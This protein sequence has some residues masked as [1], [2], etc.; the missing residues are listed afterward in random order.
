MRYKYDPQDQYA[1]SLVGIPIFVHKLY[2]SHLRTEIKEGLEPIPTQGSYFDFYL[3]NTGNLFT[4]F[5]ITHLTHMYLE[6]IMKHL[7]N[8]AKNK[9]GEENWFSKQLHKITQNDHALNYFSTL[10]GATTVTTLELT[11]IGNRADWKDV[12]AGIAG[13][14]IYGGIRH[15]VI[16]AQKR[17]QQATTTGNLEE[18]LTTSK[19]H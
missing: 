19:T 15:I 17:Q 3:N 10:F 6:G 2:I 18:R 13:A 5:L 1:G 11:G 9:L 8:K 4:S 7:S 14:F 12:P 16:N